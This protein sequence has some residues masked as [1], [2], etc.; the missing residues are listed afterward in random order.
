AFCLPMPE[1]PARDPPFTFLVN[2]SILLTLTL[3]LCAPAFADVD[4]KLDKAV[5]E[6]LPVCEGAKIAYAET[7]MKLP[8]RFSGTVVQIESPRHCA[9]QYVAVLSP[10]GGF[11]LGS[12]WP[13]ENEEGKTLEE[14][15]KNFT[16]RNLQ[17][18]V[19]ASIEEKATE[20]GLWPVTLW[21]TTEH[22]KMPLY[23]AVDPYGRTFFFGNFKRLNG[24]LLAQRTKL[25]EPLL[26]KSPSKGS[27]PVT[28]V[29]FSDFQCPSCRRSS[30]WV[31][32]IVAK[33]EGKVRY[34]RFDLPL[35]GHPWAFPAALAG[36]AIYRQK[37]DLFW[38][39][40]KT[41]YD[42]QDSLNAFTFWD[43][44]RAWAEDH[45]LDLKKYDADLH[46]AELRTEILNGAGLAL[47]SDVR[48]TPTYI[49]NGA[50]VDA[51]N[52]GEAL[53]AY[54]DKLLAK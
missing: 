8:Q 10:T 28:I 18:N 47:S 31:D 38:D 14:K 6:A 23:G 19:T 36:R 2:R 51:G 46:D 40:K 22:G 54:V 35:S 49:V 3:V 4:P 9:G 24:D 17:T 13:I 1:C 43:W 52:N 25:F 45:E 11:Y 7:G 21:Q 34:I 32:P 26:A 12:P 29:E 42:N 37:P 33:H 5:R 39:F 44:A 30:V 15:L 27:G 53:A 16:W 50:I 48:A 20:D 41:V